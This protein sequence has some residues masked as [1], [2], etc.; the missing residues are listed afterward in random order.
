MLSNLLASRATPASD[1][2]LTAA[3]ERGLGAMPAGMPIG[4]LAAR[5]TSAATAP[6]Y[7]FQPTVT[8]HT[9]VAG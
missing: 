1:A 2:T 4:S 5:A 7:G 8:S 3:A 6:N 9:V